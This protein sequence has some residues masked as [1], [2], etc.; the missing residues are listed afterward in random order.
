MS[1][2]K[3]DHAARLPVFTYG[4]FRK[5]Q[6]RHRLLHGQYQAVT[7]A[8]VEG[9]ILYAGPEYPVAVQGTGRVY[10]E[11]YTLNTERYDAILTGMD[12]IEGCTA[13]DSSGLFSRV[14]CLAHLP[15]GESV[16]A[17][18]YVG[19]PAAI[20]HNMVVVIHGDWVKYTVDR[21]AQ[22]RKHFHNS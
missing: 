10:G 2:P 6:I 19:Q 9:L 20:T 1:Y 4:T 7:A 21:L 12:H 22:L 5:G 8:H 3:L 13:R 14:R 18:I 15:A 17:W 16:E 11:L